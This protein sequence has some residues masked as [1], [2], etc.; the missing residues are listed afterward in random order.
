MTSVEGI[1][2]HVPV[3]MKQPRSKLV[4]AEQSVTIGGVPCVFQPQQVSLLA[5]YCL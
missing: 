4:S 5:L 3:K 1:S 2:S